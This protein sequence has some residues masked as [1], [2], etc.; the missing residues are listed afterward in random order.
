MRHG[1]PLQLD[2][3]HVSIKISKQYYLNKMDGVCPSPT[4]GTASQIFI[5]A[6]QFF[7]SAQCLITENWPPDAE[8]PSE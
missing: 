5:N 1:I 6:L 8:I 2:K 4:T 7:T 3:R